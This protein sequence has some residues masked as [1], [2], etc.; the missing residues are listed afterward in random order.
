MNRNKLINKLKTNNH[1]DS[2]FIMKKRCDYVNS[3]VNES[4]D[5]NMDCSDHQM[6]NQKSDDNFNPDSIL[7]KKNLS[8]H[9]INE[10]DH[11]IYRIDDKTSVYHQNND[12]FYK[13]EISS[14]KKKDSYSTLYFNK[15]NTEPN[16]CSNPTSDEKNIGIENCEIEKKDGSHLID[17]KDDLNNDDH[18][19]NIEANNSNRNLLFF[20]RNPNIY[21]DEVQDKSSS[22]KLKLE[23]YYRLSINQAIER[24]E[25]RL[26]LERTLLNEESNTSQERKRKQ[27]INLGKKES[28]FLRF[29]RTKLS[30]NDFNT[31]K[32]IG[33]G[34]FGEVRL[35]QKK[36]SGKIYAMK[37]LLKSEMYKN[38]H[39]AH[40]KAERD[41]L[42]D[43]DSPWIVSLY[44]SFQ[45]DYYL[46]L[47][48]EF[49]PGG[50]LMTMLIRWKF[51]TED[52][53]RFYIAECVLAIEVIHKLGFIHRDI[54]PDNILIDIRGHIKLS[55]FGLSTGFHKTHDLNYYR[56]LLEKNTLLK[57]NINESNFDSFSNNKD[58]TLGTSIHLTINKKKIQTW[59]KYKR[60]MAYSTVGTS[61]Y[62]PPEIFVQ[63]GYGQE[64]DWWSLGAVMFECLIGWPPFCSE[65][66]HETYYK[67]LNWKEFLHFPDD[68]HIS[69]E[70]E[71]L[72]RRL[73]TD[74][75]N[76]IGRH[77]GA[78]EIKKHP[79]FKGVNWDSL[80]KI[81][82]PFI[83]KLRSITDTRFFPTDELENV[84]RD[85]NLPNL[86]D[87]I[88]N[89]NI[90]KINVKECLPFI[91][92]TYSRFDYLTK[93]NAL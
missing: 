21:N 41:F 4:L 39:L 25:R 61:D 59:R 1:S 7:I 40:V 68:I 54:K 22:F 77:G 58:K 9:N 75:E 83:P 38:E 10:I 65:T 2:E 66:A 84:F 49:L 20:K 67:I 69:S 13:F 48:M 89:K 29:R 46:Y 44:F 47:V 27:L 86:D 73:L 81:D 62:C 63:K 92:Y 57:N 43:I 50:D 51:F 55:D 60:L 90:K 79:F 74:A 14:E 26:N 23:N 85:P 28:Q 15:S 17:F 34:A 16:N 32:V 76:R 45:D 93:K 11:K 82:A 33:K 70:S 36:D 18:K 5:E 64:Y 42:A 19:A 56:K 12:E 37:T 71:D 30:L 8:Y 24:N 53:T 72:I 87:K 52:I 3:I 35:V 88:L 80:K 31:V 78:D 91:G 6:V